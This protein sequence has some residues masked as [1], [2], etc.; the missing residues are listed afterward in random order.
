M[1]TTCVLAGVMSVGCTASSGEVRP[2]EDQLFFPT[3]AKVDPSEML[4]FVANANSELRY[5]SGSIS[6]FDLAPDRSRGR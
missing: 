3:G 1:R 5:D 2:P 4:L 6:T